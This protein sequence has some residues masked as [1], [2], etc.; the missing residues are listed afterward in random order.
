M[1]SL[2]A[3]RL[4]KFADAVTA[5]LHQA[6]YTTGD[7]ELFEMVQNVKAAKAG[8]FAALEVE[9]FTDATDIRSGTPRVADA[10][11]RFDVFPPLQDGPP[12]E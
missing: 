9:T 11:S 7:P 5:A 8:L 12:T 1:N 3:L 2:T 6:Q 10:P 4:Y